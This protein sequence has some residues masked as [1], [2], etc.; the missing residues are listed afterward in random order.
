MRNTSQAIR[1]SAGSTG[2][3]DHEVD[4]ATREVTARALGGFESRAVYRDGL[5]CLNL[6]GTQPPDTPTRAEIE[7]DGPIPVRLPDI[8]GP[9]IVAPTQAGLKAALDGAFAEPDG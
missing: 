3:C 7:A 6:H 5:G 2:R 9:E 4:Q 1:S 8:A